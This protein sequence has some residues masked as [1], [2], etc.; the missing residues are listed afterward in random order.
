M[1]YTLEQLSADSRAAM[2]ED[3][4]PA[5]RD[6]LRQCIERACAD[7]SFVEDVFKDNTDERKVIYEDEKHGFCI[8]AHVFEGARESPPHDHGISWAIYGQVRSAPRRGGFLV[9]PPDC[10]PT[11]VSVHRGWLWASA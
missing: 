3:S 4:G 8:L 10:L 9:A 7:P 1:G 5:G 6:V 11:A 2:D